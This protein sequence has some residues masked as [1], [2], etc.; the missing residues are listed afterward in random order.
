MTIITAKDK[1]LIKEYNDIIGYKKPKLVGSVKKYGLE[2]ACDIDFEES[3]YYN[4]FND[5]IQK[6][7][8]NKDKFILVEMN[9]AMYN[10]TLTNIYDKLGYFDGLLNVH[11]MNNITD[12]INNLS[13]NIKSK[14]MILYQQ[15]LKTKLVSD[16]IELKHYIYDKIHPNWS[17]DEL[18][19][20]EKKHLGTIYK[21]KD[22]NF[23]NFYIEIIYQKNRISNYITFID[24]KI[25]HNHKYYYKEKNIIYINLDD[26]ID[27]NGLLLYLKLVKLINMVL[28]KLVNQKY[29]TDED[30]IKKVI[31]FYYLIKNKMKQ[32]RKYYS[33]CCKIKNEIDV[34]SNP[35]LNKQYYE[36][37]DNINVISKKYYKLLCKKFTFYIK[38]NIMII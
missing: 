38:N 18:T 3:I 35:T 13:L 29:I 20:G 15:Y 6:L 34:T 31:K 5:Y 23:A 21:I 37:M 33:I 28:I 11:D 24:Y 14:I 22:N 1:Q 8:T 9:F 30:T 26:I 19:K 17:F 25:I 4:D 10:D 36:C 7:I 12:N 2:K 16:L 32:I 27:D